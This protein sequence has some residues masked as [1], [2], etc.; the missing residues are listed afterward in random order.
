MKY[1][2]LYNLLFYIL[3]FVLFA[4]IG[5]LYATLVEAGRHQ[6]L[7]GGAIVLGYG[8]ISGGV[9][10]LAAIIAAGFLDRS[11]VILFNKILPFLIAIVLFALKIAVETR[12]AKR[13]QSDMPPVD[14]QTVP[15]SE[16]IM[17]PQHQVSKL[18]LGMFM[19]NYYENRVLYFYGRPTNGKGIDKQ[20]PTDSV[21]FKRG[22]H[23][24]EISY[25]PPWLLP[26]VMKLDYEMFALKAL[27]LHHD[28][29][30]V[31]VNKRKSKS[32]YVDRY[33]GRMQYW[34]D[35]LF[36]INSVEPIDRTKNPIR[37]RPF[38]HGSIIDKSFEILKPLAIQSNWMEVELL[39][40][41]YRSNGTAWIK[42]HE[43]G[44]L[45]I[46]YNLLS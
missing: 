30:E 2:K 8:V 12:N 45:L 20:I 44:Q 24:L 41:E 6:G 42:W 13:A 18:G 43:E 29:I 17:G 38:D 37:L 25:A 14:I 22:D 28:L 23:S 35:F 19:P 46:T 26:E 39:D 1:F 10:L 33:S 31:E 21:V 7:A 9:A 11:R 27:T 4:F 36:A 34:P 5:L 32:T 3:S 40:S 15:V 16:G